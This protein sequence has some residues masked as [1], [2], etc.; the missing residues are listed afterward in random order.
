M[1]ALPPKR[2]F[3]LGT[4]RGSAIV[5]SLMEQRERRSYLQLDKATDKL[6]PNLDS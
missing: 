1:N 4:I 2:D 3:K 6:F 5:T